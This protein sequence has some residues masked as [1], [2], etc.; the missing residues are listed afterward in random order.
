MQCVAHTCRHHMLLSVVV[1][2]S[3]MQVSPYTVHDECK[4]HCVHQHIRDAR[5]LQRGETARQE[6]RSTWGM[7]RTSECRDNAAGGALKA[8]RVTVIALC[9]RR[10]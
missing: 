5:D 6:Q 9:G 4:T 10:G 1:G 3:C 8:T 7:G 2:S